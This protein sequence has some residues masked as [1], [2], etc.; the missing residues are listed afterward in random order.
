MFKQAIKKGA[1][2]VFTGA[3]S[4]AKVG[5]HKLSDVL[6][7][8]GLTA[9]SVRSPAL[10][11]SVAKVINSVKESNDLNKANVAAAKNFIAHNDT[12]EFEEKIKST[13][14]PGVSKDVVQEEMVRILAKLQKMVDK[15]GIDEAKKSDFFKEYEQQFAKF[16]KFKDA[17]KPSTPISGPSEQTQIPYS[18]E[19]TND[20]SE[21][22]RQN[23]DASNSQL[24][25]IEVNTK[26]TVSILTKLA[27]KPDQ[28]KP[29][30]SIK[31]S[32]D[33]LGGQIIDKIFTPN[34]L[35]SFNIS[36]DSKNVDVNST[37]A[38]EEDPSEIAERRSDPFQVSLKAIEEKIGV[39]T[40]DT[41]KAI[42]TATSSIVKALDGN[43]SSDSPLDGFDIDR[44]KPG[45]TP[46]SKSPST[47]PNKQKKIGNSKKPPF[48]PRTTQQPITDAIIKSGKN[49]GIIPTLSSSAD[50]PSAAKYSKLVTASRLGSLAS[51]AA[52]LASS[53]ALPALGVG[54]ATA[55]GYGA[56]TLLNEGISSG[57]SA[58]TGS[59]TSL[60]SWLYDKFND[61]P[62]SPEAIA[63]YN[64]RP[65][66]QAQK[67][68]A[69]NKAKPDIAKQKNVVGANKS[70]T[71]VA[72]DPAVTM[73]SAPVINSP[74]K[75]STVAAMNNSDIAAKYTPAS[76]IEAAKNDKPTQIESALNKQDNISLAKDE[77][78]Q[79]P[80]IVNTGGN[81]TNNSSGQ[82]S[83]SSP[84]IVA[85]PVR[86]TES[87]YERVQMK[88]FWPRA[89]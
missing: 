14:S 12:E 83:K 25:N 39:G 1:S 3:K 38:N 75:M 16:K 32:L 17:D 85:S 82:S 73:Q 80:I 89:K 69:E 7:E 72:T 84:T 42:E 10:A 56:G 43:A 49:K 48:T 45:K 78:A 70:P 5:A 18:D 60:G 26:D 59:E 47:I 63:K 21:D 15:T 44:V 81:V 11:S 76:S 2:K 4:A 30:S 77:K 33:S 79:Q 36:N 31:S 24:D 52:S 57:L 87:T 35:K 53:Y 28:D 55:A 71:A 41:I 19:S 66:I 34:I 8:E 86:N 74:E 61:D 67:V 13:A 23:S 46:T 29:T 20:S 40:K 88:D 6:L 50:L 37:T 58:I 54:A 51:G 27:E 9:I 62:N 22:S 68:A 65:E 64:A